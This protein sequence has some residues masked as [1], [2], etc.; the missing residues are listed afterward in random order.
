MN[1]DPLRVFAFASILLTPLATASPASAQQPVATSAPAVKI[2][3]LDREFLEVQLS[4]QP[5]AMDPGYRALLERERQFFQKPGQ[6]LP[7]LASA[8]NQ[9]GVVHVEFN[10]TQAREDFEKE[11]V[12]GTFVFS[13][14]D[15]FADMFIENMEVLQKIEHHA[16]VRWIN[17]GDLTKVPNPGIISRGLEDRGMEAAAVVA[18]LPG[19][20]AARKAPEDVI[21]GG[22]KRT[23]GL[24]GK[25]VVIVIID[26]GIDFR[27]PDFIEADKPASRILYYWDTLIYLNPKF[28]FGAELPPISAPNGQP[29]GIVYT[30][31][32]LSKDLRDKTRSVPLYDINGHGTCCAG[33]AAGNGR[34]A[35]DNSAAGEL[36]APCLGAASEADLIVVRI[37]WTEEIS[38]GFLL[39]AIID[40][41]EEKARTDEK[42]KGRPIVYSCSWGSD[43]G[44]RA[45]NETL[46]RQID[47]RFPP[48]KPGRAICIA[49]GN[50]GRSAHHGR[51]FLED[52]KQKLT[53]EFQ[54][55]RA[56]DREGQS[57]SI[58]YSGAGDANDLVVD[59]V[60]P[61]S[62][63]GEQ[64]EKIRKAV[65]DDFKKKTFRHGV[66]G[67]LVTEVRW[68]LPPGKHE[69]QFTSKSGS[70][71]K[72][73]DAYVLPLEAK[74]KSVFVGKSAEYGKQIGFP[75]SAGNAI[76]VGS[77]DWNAL[78][79]DTQ[80]QL[81][82]ASFAIGELSNY[83][84]PGP[85]RTG[86]MV[87]PDIVAPGQYWNVSAPDPTQLVAPR[88][89]RSFNGTSA[90]TPY[91]A[92]VVAL[93]M[94]KKPA[95]TT[96]E[97]KQLFA[98]QATKDADKLLP[99][100]RR[101]G[102]G[103]GKL[104]AAAVERIMQN[105]K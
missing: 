66:L 16:A 69:L 53:W 65:L 98:T 68:V 18:A 95:I 1:C 8:Y 67:T 39:G 43:S 24:T 103:N 2:S 14:V 47:A 88:K 30:R 93:M 52:S 94:Q 4:K 71:L 62:V 104:D 80:K 7:A 64:G 74:A 60:P 76:T 87:K 37:A 41:V 83:S 10:S 54:P 105:I 5:P 11:K 99:K 96:G 85:V 38:Y 58:Y 23:G 33:V 20:A 40:W 25:G 12:P 35:K 79:F 97:I 55:A 77:Y 84:N 101:S 78:Y 3:P 19:P 27:N 13:K 57:F 82:E 51:P 28:A 91:V 6:V 48:N 50:D 34:N 29:L 49:A 100:D 32:G 72:P 102:W 59:Y 75:A 45:G 90:A 86:T 36:N 81:V 9:F 17:L 92:G 44:D 56:S 73:E 26:T 22:D 63:A 89:Y 46:E 21:R 42:L 70:T 15:R 61:E 31:E